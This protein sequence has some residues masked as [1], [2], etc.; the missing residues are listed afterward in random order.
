MVGTGDRTERLQ[1][2]VLRAM[3]QR[4]IAVEVQDTVSRST[5]VAGAA[6]ARPRL[7]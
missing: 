2:R 5:R 1:A 7:R 3:R 6:R 4:G